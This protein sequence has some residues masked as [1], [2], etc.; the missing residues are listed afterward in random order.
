MDTLLAI[1]FYALSLFGIDVGSHTRVDRIRSNGSDVLYST[2]VAQPTVTRF[3]CV[4]SASGQ[5]Y[6]TLYPRACAS[7][8]TP[9]PAPAGRGDRD[10]LSRPVERFAVASG[11]RRQIA[12]LRGLRVCVE[13]QA[14]NAD[15][16]CDRPEAMATR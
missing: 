8:R 1:V 9:A 14:G 12:A 4:R 11:N 16:G 3:E 10:C 15:P 5:C 7:T 2:I 6:Y 13:A